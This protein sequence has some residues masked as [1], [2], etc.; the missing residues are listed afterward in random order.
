M[1]QRNKIDEL[2]LAWQ[3]LNI[4]NASE[5]WRTIQISTPLI[6][7]LRAGRRF[8]EN[9]EAVLFAFPSLCIPK[10]LQ[11][12]QGGGF[13]VIRVELEGDLADNVWMAVSRLQSGS[14]DLF[15]KMVDDICEFL[16]TLL[17]NDQSQVFRLLLARI[18]DWQDFMERGRLPVLSKEAEIGLFGELSLL[19]DLIK[20]GIPVCKAVESW[21]GPLKGTWDF[22]T[23]NGAV[24]VKSTTLLNEFPVKVGSLDQLDDSYV[25]HLLLIGMRLAF[26]E[27]G[28]SLPELVNMLRGHLL[29]NTKA[30]SMFSQKLLKA[31]FSE[32]HADQYQNRF[33][34]TNERVYKVDETFPRLTRKV[35]PVQISEVKYALDLD[36][37]SAAALHPEQVNTLYKAIWTWN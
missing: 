29:N 6:C 18:I 1:E 35:I 4:P 3:A 10:D 34:R 15:Q 30:F 26:S 12:P 37:I 31:G 7:R 28:I 36:A 27:S 22:Q 5:G 2:I 13:R 9:E 8:P 33:L 21:Q 20:F 19:S 17:I 24:E 25:S 32:F 11:L 14:I 16:D 23:L